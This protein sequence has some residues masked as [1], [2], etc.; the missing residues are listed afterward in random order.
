MLITTKLPWIIKHIDFD[1]FLWAIEFRGFMPA[2]GFRLVEFRIEG[3]GVYGSGLQ[4]RGALGF[5]VS[6]FRVSFNPK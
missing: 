3:F 5:A 2:L 4:A 1:M 6:G